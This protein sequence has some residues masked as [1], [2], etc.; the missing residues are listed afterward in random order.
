MKDVQQKE[1]RAKVKTEHGQ[2]K[3]TTVWPLESKLDKIIRA[4]AFT[5]GQTSLR[6]SC[7]Q[8]TSDEMAHTHEEAWKGRYHS[9]LTCTRKE[10]DEMKNVMV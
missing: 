7:E 5:Y 6:N 3:S 1:W 9:R 10:Q 4:Y 2:P 8:I